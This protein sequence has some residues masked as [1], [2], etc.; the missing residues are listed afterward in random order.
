[1]SFDADRAER[2]SLGEL[3]SRATA[4][5]KEYATAQVEVVKQTALDKVDKAKIGVG[6]LVGAG[7]FAYA[8]LIAFLVALVI[9][10]ADMIGPV[11]GGLV[12]LGVSLAIAFVM[13]KIGLGKL[14][15]MSAPGKRLK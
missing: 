6:L 2:P 13:A 4:E 11:G 3:F 9:W 12:V 14:S 8:A 5:G 7:L 15:A 10:L 1:M